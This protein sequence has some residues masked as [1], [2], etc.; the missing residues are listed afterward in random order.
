MSVK[1]LLRMFSIIIVD[2][3]CL[4]AREIPAFMAEHDH[5]DGHIDLPPVI[6][7]AVS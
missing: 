7:P 6:G 5:R 3:G 1:E 4:Q 2:W